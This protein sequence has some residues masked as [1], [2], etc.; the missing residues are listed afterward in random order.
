MG[1][2]SKLVKEK[3]LEEREK[4]KVNLSSKGKKLEYWFIIFY[5]PEDNFKSLQLTPPENFLMSHLHHIPWDFSF[6]IIFAPYLPRIIVII[7][8]LLSTIIIVILLLCLLWLFILI[9]THYVAF[10]QVT[11]M[12]FLIDFSHRVCVCIMFSPLPME[13]LRPSEIG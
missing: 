5:L 10:F 4:Y 9:E 12:N 8:W 6:I 7:M 3:I 11:Y 13:N 2:G 1:S